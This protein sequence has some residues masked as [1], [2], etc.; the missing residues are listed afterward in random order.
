MKPQ[1]KKRLPEALLLFVAGATLL[2]CS[3][4]KA[5]EKPLTPV[6]VHTVG[7]FLP[8]G[9]VGSG[10]RYSATIRPSTQYDLAF[11]T[12]GYVANLLEVRGADGRMRSLQE[13]DAVKRGTALA[14]LRPD[15]LSNKVKGAEAQLAEARSSLD[16]GA[17]QIAEAE[18]ALRQS[19]R[20][21]DRAT[22]LLESGSLTAPE[23]DAARTRFEMAEAKV[24]AAKSQ[25]RLIQAKID[26]ARAVLADAQLTERDGVLRAP[27]DGIVLRRV[28]EEG[29]LVAPGAPILTI[30]ENDSV[31]ALFG[32]PDT[33]VNHLKLGQELMLTTEAIPGAEFHGRITRISAQADP[34][35]R[36]FDVEVTV[37]RPPTELRAG[38]IAALTLPDPEASTSPVPVVPLG[39]V[40]RSPER[41]DSYAVVMITEEQGRKIARR[42]AVRLGEAYGN[43]IAV[44]EGLDA[45]AQIVVSGASV[46]TD[47]ERVQVIR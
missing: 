7:T 17:A 38:M 30:A 10:A 18:A 2:G 19:R 22:A 9:A 46:V 41:P 43:L 24:T 33:I 32:A 13:G 8:A 12:G 27:A 47:G 3:H 14:R 36:V 16:A 26:G 28:V 37:H 5:Y 31:K 23:H 20:D 15:D 39:A 6:R 40:V 1:L 45:G 21:L 35:T 25:T 34:R 4:A 42:R 11:K 44:S 29:A